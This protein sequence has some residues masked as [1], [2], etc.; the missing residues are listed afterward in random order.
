MDLSQI[1]SITFFWAKEVNPLLPMLGY[2]YNHRH[3]H[4]LSLLQRCVGL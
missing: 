1:Y 2:L 3:G 4:L